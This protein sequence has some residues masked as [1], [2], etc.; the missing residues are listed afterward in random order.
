M[1]YRELR[2]SYGLLQREMAEALGVHLR[3]WQRLEASQRE[4]APWHLDV[5][6]ARDQRKRENPRS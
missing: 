4:V 3:H 2:A 1:T 5:L 6:W